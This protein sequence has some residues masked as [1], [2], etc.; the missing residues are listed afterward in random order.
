MELRMTWASRDI[1]TFMAEITSVMERGWHEALYPERR[2]Y[3]AIDSMAS[4]IILSNMTAR[5]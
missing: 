3:R 4:E 2:K 1:G 5:N